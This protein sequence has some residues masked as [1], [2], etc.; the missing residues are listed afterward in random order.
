MVN[1]QCLCMRTNN[2]PDLRRGL[3]RSAR[4]ASHSRDTEHLLT[5]LAKFHSPKHL[6]YCTLTLAQR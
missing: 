1:L 6:G 2:V 5:N 4:D 3:G